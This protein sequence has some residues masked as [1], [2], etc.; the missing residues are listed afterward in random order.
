[1]GPRP[2]SSGV[3]MTTSENELTLQS[4][5]PDDTLRI[6]RILGQSCREIDLA[7]AE[8]IDDRFEDE[9]L[10]DRYR[11]VQPLPPLS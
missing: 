11:L 6:G 2:R 7:G 1:M 8:P 10:H 4:A 3:D 9:E 5:G